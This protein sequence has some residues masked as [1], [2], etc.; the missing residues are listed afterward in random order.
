MAIGKHKKVTVF[1]ESRTLKAAGTTRVQVPSANMPGGLIHGFIV[2][3]ESD[4][5]PA[6]T[7]VAAA[8]FQ[9]VLNAI[10][11]GSQMP[12]HNVMT[13]Y[14]GLRWDRIWT[15][16]QRLAMPRRTPT[17]AG[18]FH[19]SYF[20]PFSWPGTDKNKAHRPKDTA[21]LNIGNKALPFLDLILGPYTDLGDDI[22]GAPDVM[23][24]IEVVY[25]PVVR[26][27]FE[28]PV[29]PTMSGDRPG[30]MLVIAE[31]EKADLSVN[32]VAQLN[33]SNG[34]QN[35]LLAAVEL[36]AAGAEV[37]DTFVLTTDNPTEVG[38]V[39][40]DSDD[41]LPGVVLANHD[42]DMANELGIA[43]LTAGYHFF[44]PTKE[45][46]LTDAVDLRDG[47]KYALRFR[48]LDEVTNV[49]A[50]TQVDILSL[51]D[52]VKAIHAGQ[53]GGQKLVI[54]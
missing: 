48:N 20:L 32:P 8:D 6:G 19:A 3:L 9:K 51:P 25:E 40:G 4:A 45:G 43:A 34:R 38:V 44:I 17:E 37:A 50:I 29:D 33:T 22:T 54:E 47:G 5:I 52:A 39:K 11:Y 16:L 42:R 21:L 35:I 12:K 30:H 10:T 18:G 26:A 23:V 15:Q 7:L 13:A 49:L 14:P 46:K 24:T 2:H 41:Y 27:G 1:R 28:D 31:G 53:F 36:D